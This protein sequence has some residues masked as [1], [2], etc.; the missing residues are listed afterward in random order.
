[1][2]QAAKSGPST[3]MVK[4]ETGKDEILTEVKTY[5]RNGW[6]EKKKLKKELIPYFQRKEEIYIENDIL[7][8][9]HRVIIPQSLRKR[10]LNEVHKDHL[11]IVKTRTTAR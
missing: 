10:M 3:T 5:I 1:M 4:M 11:G 2:L 7:L 6:P 8:W 9:G